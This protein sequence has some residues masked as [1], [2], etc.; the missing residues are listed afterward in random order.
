[1]A[2]VRSSEVPRSGALHGP[3]VAAAEQRRVH[4]QREQLVELD[5][6]LVAGRERERSS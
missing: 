4:E 1:M 5:A 2:R 3:R 6:L